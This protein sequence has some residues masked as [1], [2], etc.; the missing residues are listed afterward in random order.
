MRR[1]AKSARCDGHPQILLKRQKK[2]FKLIDRRITMNYYEAMVNIGSRPRSTIISTVSDT[3][4]KENVAR[5]PRQTKPSPKTPAHDYRS[6]HAPRY[7]ERDE[8]QRRQR[9]N[10]AAR[11][12]EGDREGRTMAEVCRALLPC[13]PPPPARSPHGM[14]SSLWSP[15]RRA[16]VTATPAYR[17]KR[18][19]WTAHSRKP[20]GPGLTTPG[21]RKETDTEE[22]PENWHKGHTGLHLY[23]NRL[24]QR[25]AFTEIRIFPTRDLI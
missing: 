11:R 13:P 23:N 15:S 8:N 4:W 25:S 18:I 10:R 17:A 3:D 9:E 20:I 2:I 16:P 6:L 19:A 5:A 12:K 7:K 24:F 1:H 21:E 14:P 22:N